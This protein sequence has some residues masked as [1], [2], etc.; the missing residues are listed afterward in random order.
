[1]SSAAASAAASAMGSPRA[2]RVVE[3]RV[4]EG[5]RREVTCMGTSLER[6]RTLHVNACE[7]AYES[8]YQATVENI[9]TPCAVNRV[10][11]QG[12]EQ[13]STNWTTARAL[14]TCRLLDPKRGPTN[15]CPR[16]THALP[17]RKALP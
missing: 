16:Q 9:Q 5:L 3:L 13:V 6:C 14:G 11:R 8:A 2:G 4:R 1:M 7:G 12:H 17:C 10:L 15:P